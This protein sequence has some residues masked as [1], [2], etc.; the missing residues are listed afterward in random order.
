[1]MEIKNSQLL[2]CTKTILI[3]LIFFHRY[4][5]A[6]SNLFLCLKVLL[7]SRTE[8]HV[9]HVC[10]TVNI[11]CLPGSIAADIKDWASLTLFITSSSSLAAACGVISGG[12]TIALLE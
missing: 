8:V 4:C 7:K 9:E 10:Y 3:I 12:F 11:I 1:M 6:L 5:T 2:C